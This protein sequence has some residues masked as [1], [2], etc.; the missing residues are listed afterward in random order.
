VR[1]DGEVGFVLHT[2]PY[3]ETSLLV[4]LLTVH[5]G[6]IRCVAKGYRKPNKKGISRALFPYTEH[7]FS[8]QGRGDLKTLTQADAM[9]APVFLESDRLFTGLYVNELFYRLLHE[10]DPHEYL[11]QQ[12]KKF[13]GQLSAGL[14]EEK[15]LRDLEMCLL[16]E[17]GYGLVL[18]IEAVDGTPLMSDKLYNYIPERGLVECLQQNKIAPGVYQGSDIMAFAAREFDQISVARMAKQLLRS[19]IDFYLGGQKLHSRELYRQHLM[20]V[21]KAVDYPSKDSL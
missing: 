15:Q 17:L 12:Y 14:S 6:R 10:H 18:D 21:E 7:Q 11:F 4:D 19:V 1:V 3:R 8:W 20:R 16:E 5:H 13:L 2:T 9:Y